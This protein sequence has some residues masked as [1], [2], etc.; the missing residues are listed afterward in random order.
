MI[1]QKV[2]FKCLTM[3]QNKLMLIS[4]SLD[5]QNL[6]ILLIDLFCMILQCC[7]N[8]VRRPPDWLKTNL[9]RVPVCSFVTCYWR[10]VWFC[11]NEFA[12][13]HFVKC[14]V[15]AYIYVGSKFHS[16][17]QEQQNSK[18]DIANS[19]LSRWFGS[20]IKLR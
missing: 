13:I 2:I 12:K 20:P 16:F 15:G 9:Y 6:L 10:F 11:R 19:D 8:Y 1:I 14:D 7:W 18:I 5:A 4:C 17:L 3:Y